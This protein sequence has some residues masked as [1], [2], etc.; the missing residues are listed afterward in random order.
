MKCRRKNRNM[1][2]TR[3]CMR[4]TLHAYN[5][6]QQHIFLALLIQPKTWKKQQP[7]CYFSISKKYIGKNSMPSFEC[8]FFG[9]TYFLAHLRPCCKCFEIV[10]CFTLCW[11]NVLFSLE[12]ECVAVN[13]FGYLVIL[14]FDSSVT[15]TPCSCVNINLAGNVSEPTVLE[16]SHFI[17]I[18]NW[19]C[20]YTWESN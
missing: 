8:Y 4:V 16:R 7:F 5:K 12:C 1:Y 11:L 19:S 13:C 18:T 9:E 2:D 6:M 15:L 3:E 17:M 10:I 20:R 14:M